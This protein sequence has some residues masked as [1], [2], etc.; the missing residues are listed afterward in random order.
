[1]IAGCTDTGYVLA[2]GVAAPALGGLRRARSLDRYLTAAVYIGLG[3]F[4]AASGSRFARG[5]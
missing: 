5:A 3:L 2:A 4:T 1:M